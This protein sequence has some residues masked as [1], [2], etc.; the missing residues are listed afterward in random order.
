MLLSGICRFPGINISG[1][2]GD[3]DDDDNDDEVPGPAERWRGNGDDPD[4]SD[5]PP[6]GGGITNEDED[7]PGD[8]SNTD[9]YIPIA[10]GCNPFVYDDKCRLIR[11]TLYLCG[12]L[13]QFH[14]HYSIQAGITT[15][16]NLSTYIGGQWEE[17]QKIYIKSRPFMQ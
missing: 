15:F 13:D 8:Y 3:N 12:I 2:R 17:Y 16:A 11:L 6:P 5:P 1:G 10:F 14:C 7:K 4:D 9:I